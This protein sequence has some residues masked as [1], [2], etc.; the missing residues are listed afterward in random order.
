MKHYETIWNWFVECS[1]LA[2]EEEL[3]QHHSHLGQP[4]EPGTSR[5]AARFLQQ[6]EAKTCDVQR[7]KEREE[8]EEH[9]A[10][11]EGEWNW[12][13]VQLGENLTTPDFPQISSI[14]ST[15]SDRMPI[16]FD[17]L[18]GRVNYTRRDTTRYE[19]GIRGHPHK[20]DIRRVILPFTGQAWDWY[21]KPILYPPLTP[22]LLK[23]LTHPPYLVS[24]PQWIPHF[25]NGSDV[26]AKGQSAA[27][28]RLSQQRY[29]WSVQRQRRRK[30]ETYRSN[31]P[32]CIDSISVA[33][34]LQAPKCQ[35]RCQN[36]S[37]LFK[38][39]LGYIRDHPPSKQEWEWI[40]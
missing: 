26:A 16:M 10:E 2:T 8:V 22:N 21:H 4:K 39:I 31:V 7:R 20:K 32:S 3:A 33:M 29:N 24:N 30:P 12:F 40:I 19:K 13:Q 28:A 18:R 1:A 38:N 5:P 35:K 9:K 34:S 36:R 14:S 15:I 6:G 17:R 11:M 23:S 25:R 37:G 27:D